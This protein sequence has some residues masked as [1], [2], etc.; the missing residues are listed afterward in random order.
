MCA[1]MGNVH[2][3]EAS[4][5]GTLIQFMRQL[6]VE[7]CIIG[8]EKNIEHLY[9]DQISKGH[10]FAYR[11]RFMVGALVALHCML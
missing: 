11:F 8:S 10:Y 5:S 3:G 4:S 9:S 6:I 7:N 1:L 2:F